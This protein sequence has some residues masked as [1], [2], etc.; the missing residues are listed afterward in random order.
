MAKTVDAQC[1][2]CRKRFRLRHD[3]LN[4][5][6]RCP[7]C[8]TIVKIS[9]KTEAGAE[10]AKALRGS[11]S[12]KAARGTGPGEKPL[13]I[14]RAANVQGGI[15]NRSLAIVWAVLIGLGFIGAVIAMIL[16]FGKR[17]TGPSTSPRT[18]TQG[19]P[20]ARGRTTGTGGPTVPPTTGWAGA[21]SQEAP[22]AGGTP[23]GTDGPTAA[24]TA[25]QPGQ[26]WTPAAP[27]VEVHISRPLG[28][29]FDDTCTYAVGRITN[30]GT[31]T[32]LA[33]RVTVPLMESREGP[34]V[35][36][37]V[38]D[39]LNL[40]PGH[41]APVVAEL[42]HGEGVR[43]MAWAP[44]QIEFNPEGVPTQL[45]PLEVVDAVPLP[46]PNQVELSGLIRIHVKNHGAVEVKE[47]L[48]TALLVDGKGKIVGALKA[49]ATQT[50]QPGD[51]EEV[52]VEWQNCSSTLVKAVDVWAQPFYY[53]QKSE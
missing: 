40:P 29:Y 7:H 14:H 47:M 33:V 18:G 21:P 20:I 27:E 44:G 30:R 45:P 24:G 53:K 32:V 17:D 4:R 49:G 5:E 26:E 51:T 25:L 16:V 22:T 1:G 41:T 31:V 50:I 2:R 39:I 48:V 28:G 23:G 36:T 38:A 10:A 35:G 37:A 6:V 8:K 9:P 43:A 46:S 3:Q 13:V 19:T 52:T 34:D 15:R 42:R 11:G 12:A